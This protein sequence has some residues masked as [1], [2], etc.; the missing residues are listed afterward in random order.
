MRRFHFVA[1]FIVISLLLAAGC[2]FQ[3]TGTDG[4]Y[5][6]DLSWA[7]FSG[8]YRPGSGQSYIVSDFSGTPAGTDGVTVD[9]SQVIA[10]GN[11]V[12]SSFSATLTDAPISVGS[13]TVY[14][15]GE[16]LTDPEGDGTL[17][18]SLGASGTI[19]YNT[20]SLSV[21]FA[22]FPAPDEDVI[23][24]YLYYQEGTVQNPSPGSSDEIRTLTVSQQGSSLVFVDSDGA[25]YT[26]DI[27]GMSTPGGLISN[28][29]QEAVGFE[30]TAT[31]EVSGVSA[32]GIGVT[33]VGTFQSEY[34]VDSDQTG[35]TIS[36]YLVDR[37]VQG[38]WIEDSGVTGD[39]KGYSTD[40]AVTVTTAD[41]SDTS[42]N[43]T[44]P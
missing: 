13:L 40:V 20:G 39:V 33:I 43:T 14:Y 10:Q 25:Q 22:G 28:T 21:Q 15:G 34:E 11:G 42:P 32:S 29:V 24:T 30:V 37:S 44:T 31:F 12:D 5:N 36:G 16:S 9:G 6:S 8:V 35:P 23:A 27:T 2:E 17:A 7:N 3:S 18:G 26:G 1:G 19:N 4:G 41:S 38:T